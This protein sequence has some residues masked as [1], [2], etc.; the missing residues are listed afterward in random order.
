MGHGIMH[1]SFLILNQTSSCLGLCSTPSF[2]QMNT[3]D[4]GGCIILK[5]NFSLQLQLVGYQPAK[6]LTFCEN[7]LGEVHVM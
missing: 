6:K 2:S 7:S 1:I 3:N 5:L 4:V